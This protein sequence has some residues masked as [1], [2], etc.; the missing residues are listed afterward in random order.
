MFATRPP[1]TTRLDRRSKRVEMAKNWFEMA[2]LLIGGLWAL[3]LFTLKDAPN[4]NKELKSDIKLEI[5][6]IEGKLAKTDS[7]LTDQCDLNVRLNVKNIGYNYLYVDSISTTIW[8]LPIDSVAYLHYLD[9]NQIIFNGAKDTIVSLNHYDNTL[10]GYYPPDA[11]SG[12][13]FD[14]IIP[15]NPHRSVLIAYTIYGH[16]KKKIFFSD[17][18][19]LRGYAWKL[20]CTP[21]NPPEKPEAKVGPC[22]NCPT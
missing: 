7:F 16:G 5:D 14:F 9:F 20:Q 22:K 11:E 17:T 6:S 13:D 3:S 1:D 18:L 8:E 15:L 12:E 4:F 10:V 19:R 21:D 2:A